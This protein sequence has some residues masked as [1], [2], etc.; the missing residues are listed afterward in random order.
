MRGRPVSYAAM[1]VQKQILYVCMGSA[2][3]QLGGYRLIPALQALIT[4]HRLEGLVELKGA[5]CLDRCGH[6]RTVKFEEHYLTDLTLES[7]DE[8]FAAEIL[9]RVRRS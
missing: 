2:C 1:M 9:P 8:R 3:H 7:L 5:F 6:G 4:R